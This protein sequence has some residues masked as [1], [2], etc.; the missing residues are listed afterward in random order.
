M[1]NTN[2]RKGMNG[3]ENMELFVKVMNTVNDIVWHPVMC[4]FLM[5]AAVWFTVRLK[6][7]QVRRVKDMA[8]CLLEKGDNK[9]DK[10][11]S[12]FQAFA[13]TVG[14]RI[15]TGNIAGTATAIFMGGPGA[16]VLDVDHSDS[17]CIYWYGRV[18]PWSGIQDEKL[19][20]A[21]RRTGVL[22]V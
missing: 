6:G 7:M 4:V 1:I 17:R 20:R 12:P 19:R 3:V 2:D 14:G 9:Q 15:G 16:V 10:A 8:K 13:T 11:L 21:D 5:I 22:Y 18:Y